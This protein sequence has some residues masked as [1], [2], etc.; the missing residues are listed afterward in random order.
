MLENVTVPGKIVSLKDDVQMAGQL[1]PS[2]WPVHVM[3]EFACMSDHEA[4]LKGDGRV[5][6]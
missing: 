6:P 5:T 1:V 3:L 4:V 2:Y